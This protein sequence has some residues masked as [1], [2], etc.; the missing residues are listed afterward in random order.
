[1]RAE[2]EVKQLT[3]KVARLERDRNEFATQ[4]VIAALLDDGRA[5]EIV[6]DGFAMTKLAD[7]MRPSSTWTVRG[8]AKIDQGKMGVRP[9]ELVAVGGPTDG[10]AP[11]EPALAGAPEPTAGAPD[12][13]RRQPLAGSPAIPSSVEPLSPA[14]IRE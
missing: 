5:I 8:M 12:A 13:A 2:A 7:A 14:T 4:R 1:M 9:T 10:G 6:A 11:E 3:A